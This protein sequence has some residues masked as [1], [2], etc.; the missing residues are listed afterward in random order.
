MP[1]AAESAPALTIRTALALALAVNLITHPLLWAIVAPAATSTG[2]AADRPSSRWRCVEGTAD[3]RSWC[4]G[5][6]GGTAS[7]NR[8]GWSLLTA[9]GVNT[10]SLLVG[11][12][13]L[14][15]IISP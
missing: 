9:V 8:L 2:A 13:V 5:A 1:A 12:V 10:L 4:C 3:L 14:P 15:P 6:A 7:G 11:L